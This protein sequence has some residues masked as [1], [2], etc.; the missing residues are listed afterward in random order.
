ML[1]TKCIGKKTGEWQDLCV[2][3]TYNAAI[4]FM[5]E[6]PVDFVENM[7]AYGKLPYPDC[8]CV[9]GLAFF[10]VKWY[11]LRTLTMMNGHVCS[12]AVGCVL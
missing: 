2:P 5:P 7:H 12:G 4:D 3:D 6:L 10:G 8:S 11:I 1:S 9:R